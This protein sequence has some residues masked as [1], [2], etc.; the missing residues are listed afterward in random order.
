MPRDCVNR[1][2]LFF[3]FSLSGPFPLVLAKVNAHTLARTRAVRGGLCEERPL[4]SSASI[5]SLL[6]GA[7]V[8]LAFPQPPWLV[9]WLLLKRLKSENVGHRLHHGWEEE[10]P[11]GGVEECRKKGAWGRH[12]WCRRYGYALACCARCVAAILTDWWFQ[13]DQTAHV[14]C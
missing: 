13:S 3:S 7:I 1:R 8:P 14:G 12:S 4:F 10:R 6:P 9:F 2:K 5:S 11:R